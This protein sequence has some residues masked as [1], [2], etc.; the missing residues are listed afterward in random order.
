[1]TTKPLDT[2]EEKNKIRLLN[3]K[4]CNLELMAITINQIINCLKT[5]K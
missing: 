1:M 3:T 2:V 5:K 4:T